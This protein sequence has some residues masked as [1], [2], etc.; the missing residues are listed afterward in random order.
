MIY[1][2][3][4]YKAR[5][6]CFPVLSIIIIIVYNENDHKC[7]DKKYWNMIITI[8]DQKLDYYYIYIYMPTWATKSKT[9]TSQNM[10]LM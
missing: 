4:Y 8:Y 7:D 1:L 2:C 6:N 3:I 5:L 9:L 10:M